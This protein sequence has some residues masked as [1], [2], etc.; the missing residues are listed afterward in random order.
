VNT[1]A[2][3]P[4]AE[5]E[6][7]VRQEAERRSLPL[8]R[9]GS[10]E[11]IS[12]LVDHQLAAWSDDHRRGHR[13][14]VADAD[15]LADRAVRNLTGYGPLAPL[16]ADEDVW[17]VMVNAPDR[18]FVKRHRDPDG[19]HDEVFHDD[20]HVLRTLTRIL[21]DAPGPSRRLD[22]S[23]GLQDAQLASGAR[24]HIVHREL[25]RGGH[26]LVNIR[27]FS[28]VAYE[29]LDDLAATGMLDR[30]AVNLL[31]AAVTAR[32]SVV[33][34]GPPG[35]GKTTLLSCLLSELNP[36]LRVVTAEEV[37]EADIPLANV[38]GM[39]TRAARPDCGAVDLRRLVSAFLRMAP[40]VA[41]VGEVRDREALPY[42][43][44]VSSGVTGYTTIHA[45]S[46]RQALGRLRFLCQLDSERG[47]SESG[48]IGHLVAET[49]DL[50]VVC[51]R[52]AAGPRIVEISAVEDPV[53]GA[54]VTQF[55]MTQL[56]RRPDP[57]GPL[58]WSGNPS[59]RLRERGVAVDD[60]DNDAVRA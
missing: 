1:D 41:A 49:V 47:V 26:T 31:G 45:G 29:L 35:S 24:L 9:A 6:D 56:A 2:I 57:D 22:P 17:E 36:T 33:I 52:G 59:I 13:A 50:V 43:L 42:L 28:G 16:L 46:A 48:P 5:L 58:E 11:R 54:G 39:Q 32:C 4:L 27:K 20:D 7:A 38:A 10:S 51:R 53:A 3:S 60:P 19:Y 23:S 34:A 18:I 30:R 12:A 55:A 8:D 40:D 14:A 15:R 21:D 37:F 25:G 44:T